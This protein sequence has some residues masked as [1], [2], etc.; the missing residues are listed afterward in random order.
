MDLAAS[1][2]AVTE[3]VVLRLT[4]SIAAETGAGISASPAA[5]RST[6]SPTARCCA[7]AGSSA[8][9]SSRRPG[10]AGGALGAALAAYHLHAGQP[11]RRD[12]ALD[13]MQGAYLGPGFDDDES[14]G[15]SQQAGARFERLG[16]RR[17]DRTTATERSPTDKALGWFQGRMEFGPRALGNRSILGDA[18]SPTMQI[19]AQSARSNIANPSARSR[20][21]V[22]REDVADWFELDADSPYMLLVADVR[23]AAPAQMTAEEQALFGIDKLNVPRSDIPAVTHVDY[24]ARIQTVHRETNPRFHAL[25]SAFKA[26]DRLPGAGQHQLQR[27]RRADRLHARRRLSLL[28]GHRDRRAGGRQLL[29]AQGASRSRAQARLPRP[30]RPGLMARLRA[31]AANLALSLA[32]I[33]V[34][35]AVCELVVFRLAWLASDV[36]MSERAQKR[37]KSAPIHPVRQLSSAC[38]GLVLPPLSPGLACV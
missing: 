9:G 26:Q 13:G 1:I 16:E 19:D 38:G 11:R 21:S 25:I 6:A 20:P 29:S 8:S 2:Q 14:H 7:T 3:E 10:D 15:G 27:A 33:A 23:E 17:P 18:R 32:S 35:L 37:S 31:L 30:F 36:H 4:R 34:F 22:L 5:S 24:S 12:N 28:H